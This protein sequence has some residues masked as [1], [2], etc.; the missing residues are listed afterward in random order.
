MNQ[1]FKPAYGVLETGY[2]SLAGA[3][4]IGATGAVG[5]KLGGQGM[6]LTRSGTG[7]Y[8]IQLLGAKGVSVG[9]YAILHASVV[10]YNPDTDP[11]NDTDAHFIK[12]LDA[13]DSTGVI[14]FQC[15]DEAGVVRELPNPA[16]LK[17]HVIVKLSKTA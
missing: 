15:V 2:A 16:K 4:V 9:V 12:M 7:A 17:A 5:A 11:S 8:S 3:W 6:T 1:G 10:A 14:T 13:V